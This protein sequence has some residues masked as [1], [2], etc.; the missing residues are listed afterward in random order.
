MR[1]YTMRQQNGKTCTEYVVEVTLHEM[2]VPVMIFPARLFMGST[3]A[4]LRGLCEDQARNAAWAGL[5][6]LD[7]KSEMPN[8]E[9]PRYYRVKV[10]GHDDAVVTV[11]FRALGEEPEAEEL[12]T[13]ESEI[14]RQKNGSY[15]KIYRAYDVSGVSIDKFIELV[16]F[17][18]NLMVSLS[19]GDISP[20]AALPNVVVRK[21]D[22]DAL[23]GDKSSIEKLFDFGGYFAV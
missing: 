5:E 9:E 14:E 13:R 4:L 3:N 10:P 18:F 22:A 8:A 20:I 7:A 6:L 2:R 16:V 15:L 19:K 12:K 21:A 1:R 23:V 11:M 17:V